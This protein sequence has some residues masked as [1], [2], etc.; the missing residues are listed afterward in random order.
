MNRIVL[1]GAGQLGSRHLQGL[2]KCK[3]PISIEVVEKSNSAINT[4]KERFEEIKNTFSKIDIKFFN[5]N[6][7]YR[8]TLI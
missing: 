6:L 7:I 3:L 2:A 5:G 4:A 1:I 8:I